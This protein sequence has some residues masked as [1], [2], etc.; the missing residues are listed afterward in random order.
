MED[1]NAK[2]V[3]REEPTAAGVYDKIPFSSASAIFTMD[4]YTNIFMLHSL[5]VCFSQKPFA[6]ELLSDVCKQAV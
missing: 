1:C 5:Q 6:G 2:E 4:T 3:L